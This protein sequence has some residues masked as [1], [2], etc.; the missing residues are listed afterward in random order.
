MKRSAC[1]PNVDG[2]YQIIVNGK[3]SSCWIRK[4]GSI[5]SHSGGGRVCISG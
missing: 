4:D 5:G 1:A 2:T 3:R